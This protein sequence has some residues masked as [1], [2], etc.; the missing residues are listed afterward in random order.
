[1]NTPLVDLAVTHKPQGLSDRIAYGFVKAGEYRYPVGDWLDD[2]FIL[3]R[4]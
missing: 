1:M 4:G 2:E 3:R